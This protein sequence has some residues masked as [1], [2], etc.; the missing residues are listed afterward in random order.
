MHDNAIAY[1][2]NAGNMRIFP[3]ATSTLSTCLAQLPAANPTPSFAFALL[4]KR[5]DSNAL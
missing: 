5:Y 3:T 2:K 1:S 4:C